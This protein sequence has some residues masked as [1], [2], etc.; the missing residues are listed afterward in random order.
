MPTPPYQF[1]PWHFDGQTNTLLNTDVQSSTSLEPKVGDLLRC[2]ID[3]EGNVVDR[4]HLQTV[5]WAGRVVGE[6]TLARTVSKLRAALGDDAVTPKYIRTIPK[7]GYQFCAAV[8]RPTPRTALGR[9]NWFIATSVLAMLAVALVLFINR[10]QA[11]DSITA[12]RLERADG[13]YMRFDEQSNEAALA[14]Y[15]SVLANEP[16]NTRAQA[17]VAN[18][19][20]QRVI[21]WPEQRF[22]QDSSS[23]SVAHALS[24]GQLNT[25]EARLL[26]ERARWIAEKAVR[27]APDSTHALKSLGFVYSAEGNLDQAIEQYQKAINIDPNEWR[28]LINLGE[29]YQIR[30]EPKAALEQFVLAYHAM[31]SQFAVEPQHVGPWQPALGLV[32]ADLQL[33]TGDRLAAIQW[34]QNVLDITPFEPTASNQLVLQLRANG[35]QQQAET[36]CQSYA[37]KLAPLPACADTTQN[38]Q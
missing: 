15:E 14:M 2:L 29:I 26:L 30:R 20:V 28:S 10:P 3:A 37:R 35:Q 21:R 6:D 19:M 1:G 34:Y 32:I 36:V 5:L 8:S 4:A 12:A 27:Q 22:V 9:R 31:Q 38:V 13:L 7:R 24:S 18:A 25:S 16:N 33:Q 17:G 23:P 11:D